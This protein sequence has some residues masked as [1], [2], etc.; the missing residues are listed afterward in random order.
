MPLTDR[1]FDPDYD[2]PPVRPSRPPRPAPQSSLRPLAFL[3]LTA[4]VVGVTVVG[5]W[6]GVRLI[7]HLRPQP[8]A[9]NPDAEPKPAVANGPLDAD[10][11]EANTV[12]ETNKDSVVNVDTIMLR[13]GFDL[14]VSEQQTGTGSG[15]VWDTDARVVTNYHV[16]QDAVERGAGSMEVRVVT[17][18]RHKYKARVVGT[19]PDYDLAVIQMIDPPAK[20]RLKP[21]AVATSS[22]LKVGQKAFAI[23][24]P[25][26]LSLTLT[27]GII[28]NLDRTIEAPTGAPIPGAIQHT[29]Q[30]NPGNSGGP[31][32]N[33]AGKL[34]GVNTSITTPSGGNVGIGFSIPS[35][36]VND[37]VTK[38]IRN[39]RPQKPDLGV[40]LYDQLK[41]RR[42][43]YDT[44]VMIAAVVPG[45]P[46]EQAKLR[47]LRRDPQT[48]R[49]E[50]GDIILA[51]NGEAV[52]N[53]DDYQ[54]IVAK[55]RPGQQVRVRYLRDETERETTLTV[56]GV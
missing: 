9:T 14:R 47:G 21:I 30:I 33:K 45:G 12:F 40:R 42:A 1:P 31:L 56:R 20:D 39:E 6:L 38:V 34:I 52:G 43:G 22:D 27:T 26:A 55:L 25:F 2:P 32:L 36:T 3:V 37:V 5:V 24:N 15:F 23:G 49:V 50:P 4:L 53:V 7:D 44:G 51:I 54:R 16:V 17:A 41:L 19:A 18:D 8:A 29:A 28:S 11:V 10:E 35:D 13:R 46:A 48:G